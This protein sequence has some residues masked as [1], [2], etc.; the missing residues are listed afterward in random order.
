MTQIDG[1][2]WVQYCRVWKPGE[3]YCVFESKSEN[4]DQSLLQLL[5]A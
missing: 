1:A 4:Q 2:Q 5:T 3:F